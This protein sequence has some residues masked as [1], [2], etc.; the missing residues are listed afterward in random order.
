MKTID[1][2][3][4]AVD[5]AIT[6]KELDL[7]LH[8]K[9]AELE[10][11][12]LSEGQEMMNFGISETSEQFKKRL[13]NYLEQVDDQKKSDLAYYIFHRK[14]IL[15]ILAKAI[16]R[17]SDGKYV[18]ED[19]IHQLIMPL[20]KTSDDIHLDSCNLWL[21]DERLAIHDFLISS[22]RLTAFSYITQPNMTVS[23]E[24]ETVV[25]DCSKGRC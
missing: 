21:I 24:R 4:L 25:Y 18:R 19:V 1:E 2:S 17:S 14:V 13:A 16:Q 3:H 5:P 8:K 9:L 12:L 15:D 20:R 22:Y 23:S 6:D 7:I 11:N 10:S